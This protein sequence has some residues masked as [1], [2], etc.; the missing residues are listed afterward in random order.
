MNKILEQFRTG[1]LNLLVATK[2]G[3]E[4]LDI[5]TCCL[6]IRFDL[7][8][9][10]ASFIQ[11]RG[12]ARMPQSEYAFLVNSDSQNERDLI[13]SFQ[14][15]EDRMNIEISCRTTDEKF[16]GSEERVYKV[17][18]SGACSSSGYSVSLLHHYCSKLPHDE[19][20]NPKPEF[21]YFDDLGG[22]V[23]QIILPSNA[24]LH[25]ITG[26]PQSCPEAAKKDACL[27]A[28][29]QL[30]KLGAL[31]N[32][33]LP[34]R[35]I[36]EEESAV[37][38]SAF[39][40]CGEQG[41][42]ELHEMV[43]PRILKE[44][45]TVSEDLIILNSYYI[46]FCP[47][48][49]DRTYKKFGLFVKAP[50]PQDAACMEVDL[51]LAHGRYVITKLVPSGCSTFNT[52]EIMQAHNFQEMFLK[53]ILDRDE[54]ASGY[55]PLGKNAFSKSS[56]TFYLLLPVILKG[57]ENKVMVDWDIIRTCLSSPIFRSPGDVTVEEDPIPDPHLQ[58]ANGLKRIADV[59]NSLVYV[60]HK[61]QLYFI[62][63]V[64]PGKNGFSPHKGS[65]SPSHVD[66]LITTF[67]IHLQYPAQ[68]L[69]CAKPLFLL[70]N[71]L[72]NRRIVESESS[73]LDEYF[74]D[75]PPELCELKIVGFS[76]DI[77]SSV[78]LLPSFMH[79][80]ENLLVAIELRCLLAASFPEGAE[81][82]ANRVLEA[83]TTENCQERLSLERLETLGDV[84]LKFAVGRCL[85]LLND[86]LDEGELT[87][88]RSNAVNNSNLFKLAINK[89]L[90]AYIRD[91]PFDPCQFFALGR[92][93]SKFCTKESEGSIHD[94]TGRSSRDHTNFE[95]RCNKG[96]HWLQKKTI[97][98]VVEALV[99]GFIVDSG[100]KG[101]IAF[102]KWVGIKVGFDPSKVS[103]ICA[104]SCRYMPLS[105]SLD[106]A[107][108]ENSLGYSFHHKGLL[109]QAF[110]HPSYNKHGGGCY[111][112]LEFLGDAVMDY[113]ITSYL[114]SVY[115]RMKPGHLTD[116]RSVLV[117]NRAFANV[118]VARS[119]HKFL[120][121]DS[122]ALS[123]AIKAFVDFIQAPSKEGGLSE[124][125]RCPKALG[126][127]VE[128]CMGAILLDT[129]FD[130]NHVWKL[131]LSF[132][133]PI[134]K[135]PNLQVNYVRE[136]RELCQS[137]N[138][139]L[140]F[141][142]SKKGR[143]FLVEVKVGTKD[144]A[145][146]ASA[147][148]SNK[149][150]AMKIASQKVYTELKSHGYSQK[151]YSLEQVLKD[152]K[153]E[154]PKLIGYDETPIDI[155]TMGVCEPAEP[156]YDPQ[157][158]SI[159]RVSD[160][161]P[162]RLNSADADTPHP[163]AVQASGVSHQIS[164]RSRL[165]EVCTAN[166]W[167]Q[168]LFDCCIDEGPSHLKI[169]VYKVTVEIEESETR[170]LECYGESHTKK[171]GAAESA[172]QAALWYLKHQGYVVVSKK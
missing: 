17:E 165:Y 130:L 45:W 124:G 41:S 7:P 142:E 34:D 48:P 110:L 35:G 100:F 108:L 139:V 93:C 101:A 31:S 66:R 26:A 133:D 84:F 60:P 126:D 125:P 171:K 149:K 13:Q 11:S 5:Q 50:L 131:V 107:A 121:S 21:Y 146:S 24:P 135:C 61:K 4:G 143:V 22:S 42:P 153:K 137:Y 2:V 89:N 145:L 80:L 75:L 74:I 97:A 148:Y 91:Q 67:D 95:V 154:E 159:K 40:D 32:F 150:E 39:V 78:S 103:E 166:C 98:D 77:G 134:M 88:K 18:S 53:V 81:I 1:K 90:Q 117:N 9:T 160:G 46:E 15:D 167:K 164:A 104:A 69:L 141:E 118:A 64:I 105:A 99:G 8:E 62:T 63:N 47:V 79:R 59:E 128:S 163:L 14:K 169:F 27:K 83:L 136:L 19:F 71:L 3:E 162:A 6:V 25:Q 85:F 144:L 172:A 20:F 51:H 116:L 129:G 38:S 140:D 73:E 37:A 120:I 96:H 49:E 52:D 70:H 157:N 115:P 158:Y 122:S 28:I 36:V 76:K 127:L 54:L 132:L 10:V 111:Q 16:V 147:S 82:T 170:I 30:H 152:S 102:L 57:C 113:L 119:F 112:R 55:V 23:C 72:H 44:S 161:K 68:P 94:L 56:P 87:N 106:I 151:S 138:W 86:V 155:S 65:E 114:F 58:L 168:P 123:E 43:S 92:P 156:V 33:L 109:L 12:R 29:E